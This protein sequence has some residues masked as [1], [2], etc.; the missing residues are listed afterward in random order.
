MNDWNF[1]WNRDPLQPTQADMNRMASDGWTIGDLAEFR[2]FTDYLR[3]RREAQQENW[4]R[5]MEARD[6]WLAR[7]P[8]LYDCTKPAAPPPVV[9]PLNQIEQEADPF[10]ACGFKDNELVV[11]QQDGELHVQPKEKE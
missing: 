10:R 11:L 9:A 2:S 5:F 4:R 7:Q 3:R 8:N 1:V 6:R